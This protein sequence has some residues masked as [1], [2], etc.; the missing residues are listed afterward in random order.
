[1]VLLLTGEVVEQ[2]LIEEDLAFEVCWQSCVLILHEVHHLLQ[3][4]LVLRVLEDLLY[5]EVKNAIGLVELLQLDDLLLG[6]GNQIVHGVLVALEP[7]RLGELLDVVLVVDRADFLYVQV[8]GPLL[9][10]YAGP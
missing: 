3:V 1:M 9:T 4:E 10:L 5:E 8:L 2:L 7:D 6:Q